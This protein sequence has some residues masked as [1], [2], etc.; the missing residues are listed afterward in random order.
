[1]RRLEWSDQRR[2][3]TSESI[4]P[5]RVDR[6]RVFGVVFHV[7]TASRLDAVLRRL[8]LGSIGMRRVD[9]RPSMRT[10]VDDGNDS[11]QKENRSLHTVLPSSDTQIPAYDKSHPVIGY[12]RATTFGKLCPVD[13]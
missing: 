6:H 2:A 5:H 13:A 7:V 10:A 1:R 12:W 11:Q 8:L 3:A 4:R 9:R